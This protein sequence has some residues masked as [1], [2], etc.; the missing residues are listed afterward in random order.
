MVSLG[1]DDEID[2]NREKFEDAIYRAYFIKSVYRLGED[3]SHALGL[4]EGT[5]DKATFCRKDTRGDYAR[6]DVSAMWFGWNLY[7]KENK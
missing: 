2:T 4:K 1:G 6:E 7:K 3:G 5:L